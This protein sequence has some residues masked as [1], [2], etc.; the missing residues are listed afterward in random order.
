MSNRRRTGTFGENKRK[1]D[2]RDFHYYSAKLQ[3]E[4]TRS[5]RSVS[6]NTTTI[7]SVGV[8]GPLPS[9]PQIRHKSEKQRQSQEGGFRE[10]EEYQSLSFLSDQIGAGH[11]AQ[12]CGI[13]WRSRSPAAAFMAAQGAKVTVTWE[14]TVTFLTPCPYFAKG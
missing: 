12:G 11:P 7:V 9:P 5:Q 8:I 10:G 6:R 13:E 3:L 1:P 4:M 2:R 14:V